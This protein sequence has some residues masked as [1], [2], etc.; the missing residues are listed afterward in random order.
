MTKIGN[1][2]DWLISKAV[3]VPKIKYIAGF[4][5]GLSEFKFHQQLT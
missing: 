5:P 1:V 4:E 3:N 2:R